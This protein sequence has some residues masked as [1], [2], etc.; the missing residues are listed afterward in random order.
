[1]PPADWQGSTNST[2][3]G[4]QMKQAAGLI[5]FIDSLPKSHCKKNLPGQVF[6]NHL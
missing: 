5:F 3:P 1:M 4:A 6:L 2:F